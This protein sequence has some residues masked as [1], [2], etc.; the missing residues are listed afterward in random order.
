MYIC[1]YIYI[2]IY[3]YTYTYIHTHIV[4]VYIYIYIT[5]HYYDGVYCY[6]LEQP[7]RLA[8]A[9]NLQSTCYK[10]IIAIKG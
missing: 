4:C 1:V 2:Y 8:S 9:S 7:A 6:S 10:V 5:Y 3:I